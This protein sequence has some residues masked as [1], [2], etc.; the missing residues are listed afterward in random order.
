MHGIHRIK[1]ILNWN[2]IIKLTTCID[3]VGIVNPHFHHKNWSKEVN[4]LI[5]SWL[6]ASTEINLPP[7][8]MMCELSIHN[9][10]FKNWRKENQTFSYLLI[11]AKH[12]NQ[13]TNWIDDVWSVVIHNS[14]HVQH[15]KW[16]SQQV[17]D[18]ATMLKQN[19][20]ANLIMCELLIHS[21]TKKVKH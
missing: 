3:D 2:T 5:T 15:K 16:F 6:I 12:W 10:I 9:F 21:F 17:A 4:H 1:Q 7:A 14:K 20:L 8:L 11:N 13:L 18:E 19:L